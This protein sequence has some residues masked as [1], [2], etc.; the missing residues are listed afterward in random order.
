MAQSGMDRGRQAWCRSQGAPQLEVKSKRKDK[1]SPCSLCGSIQDSSVASE[2]DQ[3]P[4]FDT[5]T[6]NFSLKLS[7]SEL[8]QKIQAMI[9]ILVPHNILCTEQGLSPLRFPKR[10]MN[11]AGKGDDLRQKSVGV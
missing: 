8:F 7:S 1:M 11:S 5:I 9:F 2:S 6:V 10:R 3:V 4:S